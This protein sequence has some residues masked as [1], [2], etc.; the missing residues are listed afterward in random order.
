ML[1][2]KAGRLEDAIDIEMQCDLMLILSAIC[3]K[4]SHRKVYL[5][6]LV[7]MHGVTIKSAFICVQNV[8][9]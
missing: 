4:D 3:E 8:T 1:R 6:S 9:G 2:Q 5:T 7:Y